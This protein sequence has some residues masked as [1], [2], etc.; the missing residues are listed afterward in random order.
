M[1]TFFQGLCKGGLLSFTSDSTYNECSEAC[2]DNPEC[3]WWSFDV[4]THLC[5]QLNGC[6]ILDESCTTC[7]SGESKCWD[8]EAPPPPE[9]NGKPEK[10]GLNERIKNT[11]MFFSDLTKL[12]IVGGEISDEATSEVEVVDVSGDL[13]DCDNL[14]DFPFDIEEASSF[15]LDG[16]VVVCGGYGKNNSANYVLYQ[17]CYTYNNGSW[18]WFTSLGDARRRAAATT[19]D[20]YGWITGGFNSTFQMMTSTEKIYPDGTVEQG[21]DLPLPLEWHCLSQINSRYAILT[22]GYNEASAASRRAFIF[23]E[24]HQNWTEIDDM[25]DARYGHV[26]E[27]VDSIEWGQELIIAGGGSVPTSTEVLNFQT[28]TWSIG[29]FLPKSIS[30]AQSV[31]YNDTFLLVGGSDSDSIYQFDAHNHGWDERPETLSVPRK[32]FNVEVIDTEESMCDDSSSPGN[33]WF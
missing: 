27:V 13:V 5:N 22:G 2:Y 29:P 28:M 32:D 21:V 20:G 26:C 11:A 7:L 3:E 10:N 16:N 14:V 30:Y 25:I 9:D 1:C 15:N 33:F 12:L 23:D 8:L 4:K 24:N 31:M 17:D 6:P 19:M 18:D